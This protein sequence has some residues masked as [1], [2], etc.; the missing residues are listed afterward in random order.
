MR[1]IWRILVEDI[2]LKH[3]FFILCDSHGIQ[4]LIKDILTIPWLKEVHRKCK[5]VV[6]AFRHA[7]QQYGVLKK[8]ILHHYSKRYAFILACITRWGTEIGMINSVLR[9]EAAL[10]NYGHNARARLPKA[11]KVINILTSRVF[12]VQLKEFRQ[13]FEPIEEEL[14][15]SESH[16]A[17]IT[18]VV[19]RWNT[20]EV[21][22]LDLKYTVGIEAPIQTILERLQSRRDTQLEPLYW[23]AYFLTPTSPDKPARI[24]IR[25]QTEMVYDCID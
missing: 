8:H 1:K 18:N 6:A 23:V 10:R 21:N 17:T 16:R 2:R 14:K 9:I 22:L 15:K 4:L 13:I 7:S 19:P 3:M 25:D 5:L 24:L 11:P 12:W 20:I